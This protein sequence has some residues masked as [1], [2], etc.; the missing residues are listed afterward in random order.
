MP[1]DIRINRDGFGRARGDGRAWLTVSLAGLPRKSGSG[2]ERCSK[3]S[4][5]PDLQISALAD[6]ATCGVLRRAGPDFSTK[7]L[8]MT[9]FRVF[10]ARRAGAGFH[11]RRWLVIGSI[12]MAGWNA[13]G[14]PNPAAMRRSPMSANTHAAR[15][16]RFHM[17]VF[18]PSYQKRDGCNAVE[19]GWP[20]GR[21]RKHPANRTGFLP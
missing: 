4:Q 19:H 7:L 1:Q 3:N 14:R 8:P 11:P 21:R 20:L 12:T 6:S 15:R 5:N 18:E 13:A 9:T 17:T 10:A 2:G 16:P